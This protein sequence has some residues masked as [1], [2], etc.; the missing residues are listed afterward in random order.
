MAVK[1]S[2]RRSWV[3]RRL[4]G[5]SYHRVVRVALLFPVGEMEGV[6]TP[7]FLGDGWGSL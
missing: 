6:A 2:L 5:E 3:E 7:T 1:K 4:G